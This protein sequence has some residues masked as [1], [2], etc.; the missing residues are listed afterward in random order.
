MERKLLPIFSHAFQ[1]KIWNIVAE[2]HG[3]QLLLEVRNESDFSTIFFV[4]DHARHSLTI[5]DLSFDENW[6]IGASHFDRD[7]VV[8]HIFPESENPDQKE[9]FAFNLQD[10]Q[11]LWHQKDLSIV[12]F[13]GDSFL[14]IK[15][16]ETQRFDLTTGH[17]VT[18]VNTQDKTMGENIFL[19]YPFHYPQGTDHFNT[20]QQFLSE[21]GQS[22][23]QRGVDYFEANGVVILA[24]YTGGTKLA[25]DLMVMDM[26]KNVLLHEQIGHDLK[27]I[28]DRSFFVYHDTL[29]FVK[30]NTDFLSY[31][32]PR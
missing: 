29:I 18:D 24:W 4:Y 5:T 26:N 11:I 13:E 32:L 14:A 16:E 28:S 15:N 6:W 23:L 25:N 10:Q 17:P 8:F 21:L 12:E 1:G 9:F 19:K 2:T 27:G 7:I 22:N 31:Q 30:D 3:K 20:V